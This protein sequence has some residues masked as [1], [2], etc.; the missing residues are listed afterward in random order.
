MT[1]KAGMVIGLGL[2][3][4]CR[5]PTAIPKPKG[6]NNEAFNY[7]AEHS[8][9]D[10]VTKRRAERLEPQLQKLSTLVG[11]FH[12]RDKFIAA[13]FL[14]GKDREGMQAL[15]QQQSKLFMEMIE[16]A[17]KNQEGMLELLGKSVDFRHLVEARLAQV[18]K[19]YKAHWERGP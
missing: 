15:Y 16:L 2:L 14:L 17:I 7:A 5:S 3:L 11:E 8:L 4:G 13:S 18:T 6:W 12:R 1:Y 10:K 9:L 19:E